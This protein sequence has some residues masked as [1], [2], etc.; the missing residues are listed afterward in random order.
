MYIQKTAIVYIF[1]LK[2]KIDVDIHKRNIQIGLPKL[3]AS[4]SCVYL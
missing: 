2:F 4:N 1:E 3:V